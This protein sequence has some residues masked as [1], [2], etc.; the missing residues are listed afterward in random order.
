[1]REG[2][3]TGGIERA[4]KGRDRKGRE[5]EGK[6]GEGM[7]PRYSTAALTKI[8]HENPVGNHEKP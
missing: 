4:G 5:K 3:R 7:D 1:M 8:T 6:G 2:E